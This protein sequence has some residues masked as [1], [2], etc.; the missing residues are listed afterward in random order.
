MFPYNEEENNWIS[1]TKSKK[2]KAINNNFSISL[3]IL[4]AI[5][6]A[7][8]STTIPSLIYFLRLNLI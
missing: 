1:K 2:I 5:I 4:V 8:L 7:I 3:S 6:V